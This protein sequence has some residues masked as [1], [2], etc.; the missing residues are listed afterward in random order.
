[1]SA[2][3][4]MHE[5]PDEPATTRK[6]RRFWPR[7]LSGKLLIITT[8]FVML[9]EIFIFVPSV[10]NFRLTWLNRHFN[11]G[12]AASLALEKLKPEDV[13]D[14]IRNQLL[15][16]TQTDL[17]VV[18]RGGVSQVLATKQMPGEVARHVE[19]A[20]PGRAEALRSIRDAMDTL[21]LGGD[22]TIR[23]YG[24]MEQRSGTLELIMN[25]K[26]LREAMLSYAGNVMLISLGISLFTGLLVF[27]TLRWFL[28][29]PMQRMSGA[30]LAFARDPED[31]SLVIEPSGRRDE[32]G[33]AEEQLSSMQKQLRGTL[34]QQ[35]HLADLGLAVS[36]I[37]HDLR[38]ILA[39]AS[40]FSDRL[41]EVS[42]PVVQRLAPRLIR[43]I[44]RAV[45]Y[46]GSVL[47]YGKAGEDLPARNVV[48]LHRLCE[49]VAEALAIDLESDS[50]NKV[51][52][53]NQVAPDLEV[54]ADAEQLFRVLLN[55]SRNAV[56]AME[57][58]DNGALVKRLTIDAHKQGDAIHIHVTDTGPGFPP[59]ARD[60]LFAAFHT[61]GRKGGTG[62]GLAIAAE[63]VRAHGGT[64]SLQEGDAP[65]SRFEIVLPVS[66]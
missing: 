8:A 27:L 63:L 34:T 18:R 1:M 33:I 38:N 9:T 7:G 39:S 54:E 6:A 16:L 32:I 47:A 12:E 49:D 28:I 42:D 17:I 3:P 14:D 53:A 15:S 2:E 4:Q 13:P 64:I 50:E 10:A 55:L 25:E 37:N 46:T 23:V 43:S 31:A 21:I 52:W 60:K 58:Q 35:R 29:R 45:D 11:T 30:M 22:R 41:T 65:G 40:L 48:R 57:S 56:Q 24:P 36:K 26:P 5:F 44:D 66:D 59:E 19:L 20:M 61:S 51:Q 62:L